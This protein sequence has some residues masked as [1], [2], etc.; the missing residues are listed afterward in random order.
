[1]IYPFEFRDILIII[2]TNHPK[3]ISETFITMIKKIKSGTHIVF[4]VPTDEEKN[5]LYPELKEDNDFFNLLKYTTIHGYA[6]ANSATNI[7]KII[8]SELDNLYKFAK[9]IKKIT[10]AHIHKFQ[11]HPALCVISD[12]TYI[13][14]QNKTKDQQVQKIASELYHRTK[15]WPGWYYTS[16]EESIIRQCLCD[17]FYT[18]LL[19]FILHIQY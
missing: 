2:P 13:E 16:N 17:L 6:H 9:N 14:T 1:M 15:E 19:F 4:R 7:M 18:C 10:S 11:P 12:E 8:H 5:I 3:K